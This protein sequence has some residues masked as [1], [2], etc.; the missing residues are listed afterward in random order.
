LQIKI[1]GS[2]KEGKAGILFKLSRPAAHLP[3]DHCTA[4]AEPRLIA[5]ATVH[6]KWRPNTMDASFAG[7]SKPPSSGYFF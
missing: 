5:S 3:N 1:P 7:S 4:N 2:P 6:K